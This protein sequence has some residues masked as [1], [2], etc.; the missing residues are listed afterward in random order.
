METE[1]QIIE[2]FIKTGKA[3][4]IYRHLLQLGEPT[5]RAAEASEC[6]ADQG[7]FWEMRG[8]LYRSQSDL[9]TDLE[10]TLAGLAGQLGLDQQQFEGCMSARTHQEQ[11]QADFRAAQSEGIRS[12]PSFIINGRRLVGAL[13]FEQFQQAIEGEAGG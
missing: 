8:L 9:Y 12:R 11:I 3:R 4:L 2:S 10:A 6:A 5:L 1:P 7:A 13:P